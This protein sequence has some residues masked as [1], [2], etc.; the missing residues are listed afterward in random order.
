MGQC[1]CGADECWDKHDTAWLSSESGWHGEID[2]CSV[3][4]FF[5]HGKKIR[6]QRHIPK[7]WGS[8]EDFIAK[9]T[10]WSAGL[11]NPQFVYS[12]DTGDGDYGLWIEG[13]REPRPEDF[14][15]LQEARA[16]I[17]DQAQREV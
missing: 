9:I 5:I 8:V 14:V 3:S 2:G 11:T 13:I 1:H 10:R 6:E 17:R 15:R 16:R 7:Q 12:L 4:V